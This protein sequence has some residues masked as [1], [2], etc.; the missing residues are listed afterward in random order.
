MPGLV[1]QPRLQ[2]TTYG[3][4]RIAPYRSS[5]RTG[6]GPSSGADL[7]RAS[8]WSRSVPYV[9]SGTRTSCPRFDV[10]VD[11][12]GSPRNPAAIA[13]LGAYLRTTVG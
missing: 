5:S 10:F 1:H 11:L 7:W 3:V 9:A 13:R 2:V 4:A 8:H 12:V 6:C